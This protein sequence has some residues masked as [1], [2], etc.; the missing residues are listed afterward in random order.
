MTVAQRV[1]SDPS[2]SEV[3]IA[4]LQ[5][6][7]THYRTPCETSSPERDHVKDAIR[8][9]RRLYGRTLA[10]L[11]VPLGLRAVREEMV[12]SGFARTTVNA[13]VNRI[14]RV[15]KWAASVELIP[16]T[17]VQALAT[18]DG[19]LVGRTNARESPGVKPVRFEHVEKAL[20]FMPGPIA[21]MVRFQLLTA[22]RAGEVVVMRGC[23]LTTGLPVW[24]Y[25]PGTHK[26]AWRGKD[27][28]ILIGP[29]A[30][31]IVREFMKS[32]PGEYLFRPADSVAEVSRRRRADR[33]SKPTPS[34]LAA[35]SKHPGRARSP[36]YS[37]N[38]YG[39]AIR[40]ACVKSGA[41]AW[42]LLQLRHT[43]ATTIRARFDLESAQAV[44]GHAKADTTQI[45]AE[46]DIARARG[47]MAEIG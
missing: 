7:E 16:V 40:R 31:G 28:V 21:A 34:E 6:A 36:H 12:R 8:P 39:Q 43:A 3:L 15:F 13:R 23:D 41:P 20:P 32:E 45:Y 11:F 38:D 33:K 25:R 37:V 29:Q 5:H 2:V 35:R 4:F 9:L 1:D 18:V 22:C 27:R 17:V 47:V 10:R 14:R 19:L 30:Q 42:S 26:N 46:R 24:E 44:L